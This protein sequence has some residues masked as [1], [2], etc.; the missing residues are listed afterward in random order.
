MY[1]NVNNTYFL[2]EKTTSTNSF[3]A[4]SKI[5]VTH[6]TI[7]YFWGLPKNDAA[8]NGWGCKIGLYK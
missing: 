6:K 2:Y 7:L 8:D 4:V 1:S 3:F 5:T